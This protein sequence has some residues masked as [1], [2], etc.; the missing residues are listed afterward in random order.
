M[1]SDEIRNSTGNFVKSSCVR[2]QWA[3][4]SLLVEEV[5][6]P[7]LVAGFLFNPTRDI[8]GK[9]LDLDIS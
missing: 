7:G 3:A 6:I 9:I 2:D 1:S 5:L 4:A 8:G